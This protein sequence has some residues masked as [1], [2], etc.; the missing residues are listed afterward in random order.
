M[1]RLIILVVFVAWAAGF[2]GCSKPKLKPK[3]DQG[4]TLAEKLRAFSRQ[5][6]KT[7]PAK[8]VRA[9]ERGIA[10]VRASGVV[11]R[12]LKVG[13]TAPMFELPNAADKMVSLPR[14]LT[15]GPVV[16]VWFRG[17]WSPYCNLTLHAYQQERRTIKALGAT[18]LAISPQ[19]PDATA[20]TAAK[21][22]LKF[23]VLSDQGNEAARAFRIVYRLPRRV[24]ALL[25]EKVNFERYNGD[26]SF[27]L[28][29][30]ATYIIDQKGII[31]Y[32]FLDADYRK[33]AEPAEVIE[34]LRRIVG[35]R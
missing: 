18:L 9:F 30:C 10:A 28:P 20:K 13:D 8:R 24:A 21:N 32:A 34:A 1:R 11:A 4:P 14:L 19:M 35:R 27:E 15:H 29:L 3:G 26:R 12:A 16:V 2:S 33:R 6:R 7:A 23:D 5:F 25:E 31:R 22:K 17:A